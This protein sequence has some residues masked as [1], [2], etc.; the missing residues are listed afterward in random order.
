MFTSK[1][2]L[3]DARQNVNWQKTYNKVFELFVK[4]F[5]HKKSTQEFENIRQN[6]ETKNQH[7][8]HLGI[9]SALTNR[10]RI[11]SQS[12]WSK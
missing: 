9:I 5:G 12:S 10:I 6:V 11:N 1:Q 2:H 3:S 7:V 8:I 4:S